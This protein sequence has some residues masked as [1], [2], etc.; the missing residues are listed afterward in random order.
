MNIRKNALGLVGN[1][2]LTSKLANTTEEFNS[3][4]GKQR[5]GQES[6]TK[7]ERFLRKTKID[8][9]FAMQVKKVKHLVHFITRWGIE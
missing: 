4:L 9:W 8:Q 5:V 3:K 7:H 1:I 2:I 6:R